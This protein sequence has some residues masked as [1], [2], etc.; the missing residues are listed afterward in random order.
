MREFNGTIVLI[1]PE[2]FAKPEDLG[3]KID[4]GIA[5]ISPKLGFTSLFFSE[6]GIGNCFIN[7]FKVFDAKEYYRDGAENYV[8]NAV[9][10]ALREEIKPQDGQISIDSGTIGIFLLDEIENYNPGALENYKAGVDYVMINN[11]K[12]KIGYFRDKYNMIHYFG[13]GSTNFYTI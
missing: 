11:Y 3:K 2:K 6:T 7:Y 13:T 8:K 9:T 10:K 12:G 5:R 4:T 1:D